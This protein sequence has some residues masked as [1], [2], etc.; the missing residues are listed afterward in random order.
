[1]RVTERTGPVV[2]LLGV[3]DDQDLMVTT[4]QGMI[5]RTR[6]ADMRVIG[7]ATQGVR[8]IDLDEGDRVTSVAKLAEAVEEEA[9]G[10]AA[11]DR[12]P[13]QEGPGQEEPDT[14]DA[15]PE[16]AEE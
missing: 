1:M 14:D 2:A 12:D 15:T 6:V 10:V 8:I 7:R 11:V 4:E 13:G 5:L 16:D 9:G 3:R